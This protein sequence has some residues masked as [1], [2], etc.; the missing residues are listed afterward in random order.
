MCAGFYGGLASLNVTGKLY[1]GQGQ[2]IVTLTYGA[3]HTACRG[4][5]LLSSVSVSEPAA[6]LKAMV[7]VGL[8]RCAVSTPSPPPTPGTHARSL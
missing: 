8:A 2:A 4:E 7:G 6:V 3:K 1:R 5:G